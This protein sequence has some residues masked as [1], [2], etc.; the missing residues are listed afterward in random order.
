MPDRVLQPR[1][2]PRS[3]AIFSR[4]R[5]VTGASTPTIVPIAKPTNSN[6]IGDERRCELRR[7]GP[8]AAEALDIERDLVDAATA[9]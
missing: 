8:I 7:D 3:G 6:S 2:K 5:F 1:P 4:S 9:V